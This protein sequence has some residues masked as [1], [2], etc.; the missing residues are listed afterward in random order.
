MDYAALGRKVLHAILPDL[1]KNSIA[2]SIDPETD[3]VDKVPFEAARCSETFP[4]D[5]EFQSVAETETD[6][7]GTSATTFQK[8]RRTVADFDTTLR[9]RIN[10]CNFLEVDAKPER[11]LERESCQ[12]TSDGEDSSSSSEAGTWIADAPYGSRD[13]LLKA[14]G[15]LKSSQEFADEYANTCF[16][17]LFK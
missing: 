10:P 12:T 14:I 1:E 4:E 15:V 7:G 11:M 3:A 9:Q 16:Q 17:P 8:E 6:K 2:L 13:R 5:M